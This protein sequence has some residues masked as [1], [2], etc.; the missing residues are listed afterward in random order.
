LPDVCPTRK[1]ELTGD[2]AL[3]TSMYR[4]RPLLVW[5][6]HCLLFLGLLAGAHGRADIVEP[7]LYLGETD[8]TTRYRATVVF[9]AQPVAGEARAQ[10]AAVRCLA[11]S[12][13]NLPDGV[14]EA[15][16]ESEF[17]L[18]TRRR[19]RVVVRNADSASRVPLRVPVVRTAHLALA[20]DY[21]APGSIVDVLSVDSG[22]L[23]QHQIAQTVRSIPVPAELLVIGLRD[24]NLR[25]LALSR[26]RP[27]V[28]ATL[29]FPVP[30]RLGRGRGQL[31]TAISRPVGPDGGVTAPPARVVLDSGEN[32]VTAPDFDVDMG[33]GR[34]AVFWLDAPA[35]SASLRVESDTLTFVRP[36]VVDVPD[37]GATAIL[38]VELVPRPVLHLAFDAPEERRSTAVA[39][40][41]LDCRS[42]VARPGP[43]VWS[44][45]K[46]TASDQGTL[47]DTFH[48]AKLEPGTWA[49]R[50][51]AGDL[52]GGE[53]VD[54]PAKDL[55]RTI[56][57]RL[58]E[59]IGRVTVAGRGAATHLEWHHG[60][61]DLDFKAD[62]DESGRYRVFLSVT[63]DFRVSIAGPDFSGFLMRTSV[64]GRD[65]VVTRDFEVPSSRVDV[66]VR[67][68]SSGVPLESAK[69]LASWTP[70]PGNDAPEFTLPLATGTDGRARVPPVGA[71]TLLLAASAAGHR[72]ATREIQVSS[73]TSN[74]EVELRMEKGSGSR[75]RVFSADGKP[76]AGAIVAAD[77][78][79]FSDPAGSDGVAVLEDPLQP[80]QALFAFVPTGHLV[81]FRWDGTPEQSV[82]A[83]GS[84]TS[85]TVRFRAP[86]GRP[87]AARH[88]Q[89][90][91]GGVPVPMGLSRQGM[92]GWDTGSRSDGTHRIAGLP[93]NGEIT[94]GPLGRP[95][96][97]V[98]RRL[99]VTDII[100][101][102]LDR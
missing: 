34:H 92:L 30:P 40:E 97:A 25:P 41:L 81:P 89:L 62:S 28:G 101:L 21:P 94:V 70:R 19:P 87:L 73:E 4:T 26:L 11:G 5:L 86:D 69:V 43:V 59:V 78:A 24:A 53:R 56:A 17:V 8:V 58:V 46:Q 18:C 79:V 63:G 1:T 83:S 64:D 98:Y 39:L 10:R 29:D 85:F 99:P 90:T 42:T 60:I 82:R 65:N 52:A 51:R 77:D 84:T 36:V 12:A 75:F 80:G 7:R 48:F 32:K 76:A 49:V 33:G 38:D 3:S 61:L 55:E 88:V 95:D 20:S 22:L 96:L 57:I 66:V 15:D 23:F 54:L 50:W 102:T 31:L 27:S 35:G 14:Y 6:T 47:A 71:G 2:G 13:C 93:Q 44:L 37:R 100:E 91:L 74:L 72:E 68:A 67:D 9:S 16:V 45:C